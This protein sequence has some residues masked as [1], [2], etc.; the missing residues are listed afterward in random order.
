MPP[1]WLYSVALPRSTSPLCFRLFLRNSVRRRD[2]QEGSGG[3]GTREGK[4]P[5]PQSTRAQKSRQAR[6]IAGQQLPLSPK[7]GPQKK[8]TTQRFSGGVWHAFPTPKNQHC[9]PGIFANVNLKKAQHS[10]IKTRNRLARFPK[11]Q[12]Q[13]THS[14]LLADF[15]AATAKPI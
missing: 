13:P 3:F 15:Q 7:H 12:Q 11:N 4:W 9:R 1:I 6:A 8:G 14:C 2:V 10:K 5:V